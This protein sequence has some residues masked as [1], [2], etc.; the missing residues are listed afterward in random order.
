VQQSARFDETRRGEAQQPIASPASAP[1]R[2]LH[3]HRAVRG[4]IGNVVKA[5]Q[6]MVRAQTDHLDAA[7]L[8]M[9]KGYEALRETAH[10]PADAS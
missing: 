5:R 3:R 4:E 6:C 9:G 2:R 1:N 8:F 10:I 7:T